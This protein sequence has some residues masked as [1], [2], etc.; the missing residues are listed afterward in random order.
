MQ[1]DGD[2]GFFER[3]QFRLDAQSLFLQLGD[4][5]LGVLLG[6]HVPDHE[7]N[8]ALPLAFDPITFRF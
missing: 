7:I 2:G 5:L 8:V 3:G 6:N 4:P 1:R